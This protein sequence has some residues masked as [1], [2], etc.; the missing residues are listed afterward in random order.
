VSGNYRQGAGP[1]ERS[2]VDQ[3]RSGADKDKVIS[4]LSEW[5]TSLLRNQGF[6]PGGTTGDP[7]TERFVTHYDL[8]RLARNPDTTSKLLEELRDY[9][10]AMRAANFSGIRDDYWAH[11]VFRANFRD[12]GAAGTCRLSTT[13]ERLIKA[14]SEKSENRAQGTPGSFTV[15]LE[16]PGR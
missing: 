15:R 9:E 6:F 7:T 11:P 10:N 3:I 12:T 16:G 2:A 4:S 1:H 13:V 8:V 14:E 5:H